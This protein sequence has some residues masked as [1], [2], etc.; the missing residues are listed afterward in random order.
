MAVYHYFDGKQG[1]LEALYVE[2]HK[3]LSDA[4]SRQQFTHDPEA[5]VRNTCLVYR[6]V[7][8]AHPGYFQ[9]MFGHRVPGFRRPSG[10]SRAP[11]R[12]NYAR[13]IEVVRRWGER[14]PLVTDAE[15][16][17][18]AL[19]ACGHGLVMLELTGNAPR[20]DLAARYAVA[21]T[22]TMRGLQ[23]ELIRPPRPDAVL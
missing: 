2:G 21:I 10:E 16:A 19:W 18:H 8:L 23:Q 13:F 15:S 5:D 11:A 12:E 14:T 17:A 1:L 20:V 6:E 22:A 3:R 7:A 9:V 4:Q